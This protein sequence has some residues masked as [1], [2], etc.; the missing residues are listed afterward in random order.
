[1]EV[2]PAI[3]VIEVFLYLLALFLGNAWGT[4]LILSLVAPLAPPESP[5]WNNFLDVH[6]LG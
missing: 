6:K 1:M 5:F 3:K 2:K 4:S